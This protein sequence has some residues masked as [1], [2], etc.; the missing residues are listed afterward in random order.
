MRPPWLPFGTLYFHSV[1][2]FIRES[3]LNQRCCHRYLVSRRSPDTHAVTAARTLRSFF[4]L[5][6]RLRMIDAMP[7]RQ[8]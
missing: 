7:P 5:M 1:H 3:V 4:F 8:L 6:V 2:V